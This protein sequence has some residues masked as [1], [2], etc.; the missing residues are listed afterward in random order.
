MGCCANVDDD[1]DD[2][3]EHTTGLVGVTYKEN[4]F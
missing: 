3:D 2:D 4:Y 1:D